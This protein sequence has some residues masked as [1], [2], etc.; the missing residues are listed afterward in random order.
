MI[1]MMLR[2]HSNLLGLV[3]ALPLQ[4]KVLFLIEVYAMEEFAQ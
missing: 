3:V 2:L 1:E 4:R